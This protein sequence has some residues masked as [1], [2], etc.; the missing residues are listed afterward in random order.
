MAPG[1]GTVD[2]FFTPLLGVEL[3]QHLGPI[4]S[5]IFMLWRVSGMVA[6]GQ[7]HL[8]VTSRGTEAVCS[9]V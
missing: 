7:L 3:H 9:P 2:Q 6:S 8:A 5:V 1:H 4:L